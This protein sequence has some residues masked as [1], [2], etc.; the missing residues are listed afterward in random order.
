MPLG[1]T[2]V[3][4][5]RIKIGDAIVLVKPRPRKPGQFIIVIE[6]PATTLILREKHFSEIDKTRL[7]P[8]KCGNF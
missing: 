2:V 8:D 7:V 6:A 5:E 1:L 4:N 3:E